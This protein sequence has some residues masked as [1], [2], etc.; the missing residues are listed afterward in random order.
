[1][2]ADVASVVE[3]ASLV[4]VAAV[5]SVESAPVVVAGFSV[6]RATAV[7]GFGS[8]SVIDFERAAES[9]LAVS[10]ARAVGFLV[11]DAVLAVGRAPPVGH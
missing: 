1:L 6:R 10:G 11:V 9:L 7:A 2:A 5:E 3:V 4:A 8:I